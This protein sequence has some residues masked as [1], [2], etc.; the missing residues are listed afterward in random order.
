MPPIW[1]GFWA[2][3]SLRQGPFFSRFSINKVGL[4]RC[5]QRTAK[6]G[7]FSAKIHHEVGMKASFAN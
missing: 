3:N 6:N 7:A 5:W 4:S 1:V 2:P